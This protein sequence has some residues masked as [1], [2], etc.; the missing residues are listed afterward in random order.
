M[1]RD[2]AS[3]LPGMRE[4]SSCLKEA[5]FDARFALAQGK[6]AVSKDGPWVSGIRD[7]V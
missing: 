6:L 5:P 2:A 1:L 3:R 7:S 4:H